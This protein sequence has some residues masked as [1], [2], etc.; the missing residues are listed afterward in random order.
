MNT[1]SSAPSP[2]V[3]SGYQYLPD[4][5][6]GRGT[7]HAGEEAVGRTEG[8]GQGVWQTRNTNDPIAEKEDRRSVMPSVAAMTCCVSPAVTPWRCRMP[9]RRKRSPR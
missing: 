5:L 7:S 9:D 1:S 6:V 8:H 3:I 2:R 4:P